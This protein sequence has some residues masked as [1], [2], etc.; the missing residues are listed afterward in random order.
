M[1]IY[2]YIYIYVCI[3][4]YILYSSFRLNHLSNSQVAMMEDV[5]TRIHLSLAPMIILDLTMNYRFSLDYERHL[6]LVF[7]IVLFR[8]FVLEWI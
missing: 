2:I 7:D 4:I 8:I 5:E 6:I 1:Y 3:Y